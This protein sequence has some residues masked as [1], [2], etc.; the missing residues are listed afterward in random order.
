M[1][2]FNDERKLCRLNLI[3]RIRLLTEFGFGF[4][5]EAINGFE[6]EG[7]SYFKGYLSLHH[8]EIGQA[9]K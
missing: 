1:V 4:E 9:Y 7:I 2:D 5:G 8:K 6:S 3:N